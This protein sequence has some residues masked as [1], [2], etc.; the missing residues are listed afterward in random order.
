M[1]GKM[2]RTKGLSFERE[3]A[4]A[5]RPLF[6]DAKRLFENRD[7]Q[8]YDLENT[9]R[10]RIQCKRYRAYASLT[11]IDEARGEDD[12]IPLLVTKGDRKETL[13]ALPLSDFIEILKDPTYVGVSNNADQD[14]REEGSEK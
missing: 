5:F 4:V 6:P 8:G 9:G 10:L 1:G 13:V 11:K 3:I 12:T 7:G 2:S 14:R